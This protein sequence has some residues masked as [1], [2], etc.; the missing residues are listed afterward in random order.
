VLGRLKIWLRRRRCRV[1]ALAAFA[2]AVA[3]PLAFA[4]SSGPTRS[5]VPTMGERSSVPLAVE[6]GSLF[7]VSR[8]SSSEEAPAFSDTVQLIAAGI[9]LL[10]LAAVVKN[11]A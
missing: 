1:P 6:T 2:C 9:A 8:T 5:S 10:G 3:V 11:T 4:M 7:V